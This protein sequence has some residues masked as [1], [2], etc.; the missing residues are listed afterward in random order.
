VIGSQRCLWQQ[1]CHLKRWYT[2]TSLH[3]SYHGKLFYI[4][5]DEEIIEQ[6]ASVYLFD[7]LKIK[8]KMC[9]FKRFKIHNKFVNHDV[10]AKCCSQNNKCKVFYENLSIPI[11]LM[12]LTYFP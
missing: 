6:Q 11:L 1:Q 12:V 10:I 3:I 9:L 4:E 8:K 5:T 7:N 2:F